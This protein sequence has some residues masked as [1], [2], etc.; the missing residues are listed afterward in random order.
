M[1]NLKKLVIFDLDGTLVD[2]IEDLADG[3]NYALKKHNLSTNTL[4]DYYY[5]VGNGM[6]HLVRSALREKGSDDELYKA[7]RADFD[8]YYEKHSNDKTRAYE[9]ME[10]LLKKLSEKEIATAVLSNKAQVYL[11]AILRKAFP[12]HSFKAEFGQRDGVERKPHPQALF[13]LMEELG[14]KKEDCVLIGDSD[15]DI[16]TAKNAGI[17]SIGVLWGFRTREELLEAG[18]ENLVKNSEELLKLIFEL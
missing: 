5:F 9:G 8:S 16:I 10:E 3:V 17:D 4:S 18:A 14:F 11:G 15:V 7:V 6:E 1:K 2:S 12:Q 13:M